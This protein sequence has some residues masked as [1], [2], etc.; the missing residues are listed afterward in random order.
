[1]VSQ[2]ALF[3]YESSTFQTPYSLINSQ[4][5]CKAKYVATT[6]GYAN[7]QQAIRVNVDDDDRTNGRIGITAIR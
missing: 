6:L 2:T 1:M 5:W 7:T 3:N 4:L